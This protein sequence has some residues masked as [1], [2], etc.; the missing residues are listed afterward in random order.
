MRKHRTDLVRIWGLG[1]CHPLQNQLG[2]LAYIADDYTI[3]LYQSSECI[4]QK[5]M[6]LPHGYFL[7]QVLVMIVMEIYLC[8]WCPLI[9]GSESLVFK[10]THAFPPSFVNYWA[11]VKLWLRP[12]DI[13]YLVQK[14]GSWSLSSKVC[15]FSCRIWDNTSVQNKRRGMN[16]Q[17]LCRSVTQPLYFCHASSLYCGVLVVLSST[18]SNHD[19]QPKP[20]SKTLPSVLWEVKLFLTEIYGSEDFVETI[21]FYW[22]L[23][24]C[25]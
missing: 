22:V 3:H 6:I 11:E 23:I 5:G 12:R 4:Q 7:D 13:C 19:K 2:C 17:V 24:A 20:S 18:L 10:D 15:I 9:H 25:F 16:I 8:S 1:V 21:K 14:R